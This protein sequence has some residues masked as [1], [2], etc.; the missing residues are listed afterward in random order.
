MKRYYK[1]SEMGEEHR[2]AIVYSLGQK[3][4][5]KTKWEFT[6]KYPVDEAA[7]LASDESI[8]ISHYRIKMLVL[9][10]EAGQ[11]ISPIL[12]DYLGEYP[13]I[14]GLYE[15]L[16]AEQLGLKVMPAFVRIQ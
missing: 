11:K 4:S 12:I 3:I 10:I 7:S 1:F 15:P 8:V 16:A 6:S 13:W 2:D 14:Y 5:E 9:S